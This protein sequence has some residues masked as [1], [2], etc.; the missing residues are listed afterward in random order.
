MNAGK[1]PGSDATRNRGGM[2]AVAGSKVS[3]QLVVDLPSERAIWAR[4]LSRLARSRAFLDRVI[5]TWSL[6]HY[7]AD[8]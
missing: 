7:D 5:E 1:P 4:K 3:A 6:I 2:A 8:P